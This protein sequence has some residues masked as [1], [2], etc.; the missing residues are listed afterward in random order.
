[1]F[2]KGPRNP[3]DVRKHGY[4]FTQDES[5]AWPFP[6]IKQAK[7]KER[8][9]YIHMGHGAGGGEYNIAFAQTFMVGE[10]IE[11]EVQP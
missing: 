4:A 3:Q 6:S 5:E 10:I 11:K 2:L 7:H 9:L 1:M 8:I